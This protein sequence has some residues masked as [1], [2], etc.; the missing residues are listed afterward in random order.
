MQVGSLDIELYIC[1]DTYNAYQMVI[2]PG[3][4]DINIY[5]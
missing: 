2:P 3:S 4:P 5:T 1:Y